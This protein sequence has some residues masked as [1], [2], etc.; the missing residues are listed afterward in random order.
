MSAEYLPDPAQQKWLLTHLAELIRHRGRKTFLQGKLV[1]PTD[2]FFPDKWTADSKGIERLVRRV[3]KYAAMADFGVDL[4]L[5][6]EGKIPLFDMHGKVYGQ[7]HAGDVA[8]WFSSL[9]G[10]VCHFG[11]DTNNLEDPGAL[12]AILCHEVAHAWRA[13]YGMEYETRAED[14]PLTDLTTVYLGFGILTT[15]LSYAYRATQSSYSHRRGGYLPPEA[16]SFALAAQVV[17]RGDEPALAKRV[18]GFLETNQ[19]AFFDAARE[20]L[21]SQ[22]I[23]VLL[24]L[25]KSRRTEG[26]VRRVRKR[27][28]LIVREVCSDCDADLPSAATECPKCL[29]PIEGS[30]DRRAAPTVDVE[31]ILKKLKKD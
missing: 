29:A 19:A 22:E 20:H 9:D 3:M 1:E 5:F 23:G 6:T 27:R 13:R 18:R 30:E 21:A 26:F 16:M 2:A 11:V 17:A 25:E 7:M 12:A 4:E 31:D 15:N 10:A 8:A 14:E 28:F 24:G